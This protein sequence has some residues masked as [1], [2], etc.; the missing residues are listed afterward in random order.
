MKKDK[1]LRDTGII[2]GIWGTLLVVLFETPVLA[3]T[4]RIELAIFISIAAVIAFP[5][6]FMTDQVRRRRSFL[7]QVGIALT[8]IILLAWMGFTLDQV[9]FL[10]WQWVQFNG[11]YVVTWINMLDTFLFAFSLALYYGAA[12]TAWLSIPEWRQEWDNS[13]RR[14]KSKKQVSAKV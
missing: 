4:T 9:V 8:I 13:S 1:V 3:A 12:R 5:L 14:R 7:Y 11:I 10:T 6:Y 2:V